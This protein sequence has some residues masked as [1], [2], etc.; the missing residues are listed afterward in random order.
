MKTVLITGACINTGVAIVEKFGYDPKQLHHLIRIE[1]LLRKW[2]NGTPFNDCLI[3][4]IPEELIEIKKGCMDLTEARKYAKE[5]MNNIE[6]L[7][8]DHIDA[9]VEEGSFT[10]AYMM[11]IA[12]KL[13]GIAKKMIERYMEITYA[14]TED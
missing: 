12:Q 3:S 13:N 10:T 4:S 1:E 9:F 6:S 14:K 5:S 8:K 7:Y 2:L 11:E